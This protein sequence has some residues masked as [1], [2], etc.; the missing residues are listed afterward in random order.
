MECSH[1]WRYEWTDGRM[2]FPAPGDIYV[3]DA[4]TT[5]FAVP[6][7]TYSPNAIGS[8]LQSDHDIVVP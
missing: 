3:E 5:Q 7:V 1:E 4:D 2:P 6:S 8:Q